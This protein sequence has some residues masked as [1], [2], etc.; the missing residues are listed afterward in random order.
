MPVGMADRAGQRIHIAAEKGQGREFGGYIAIGQQPEQ[1][2]Q[3]RLRVQIDHEHAVALQ[4][5]VLTQMHGRAGLAHA[6]L[7]VGHADDAGRRAWR[8]VR[9]AAKV[10]A[11]LRDLD[12]REESLATA[13]RAGRQGAGLDRVF[14]R[15]A[16]HLDQ[17]SHLGQA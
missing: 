12:Q 6:A 15:L 13:R 14:D 7:E 2:C 3:A 1:R 16:R 9:Y 11:K 10:L 17:I 8:A 5:E 4:R